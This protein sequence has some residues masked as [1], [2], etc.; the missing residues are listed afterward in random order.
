MPIFEFACDHCRKVYQFLFRTS[1]SRKRP[2][3]PDC[4]GSKLRKLFSRFS[5][6]R[7][8][9]ASPG[10]GLDPDAASPEGADADPVRMERAMAKLEREM[11]HLDESDPRQVGHFMRRMMEE[12]GQSLGPEME[13]AIRRLES[14]EDPEKIEEDMGDLFDEVPGRGGPA[15][16][17]DSYGY[18][19]T[20]YEP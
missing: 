19:D 14:G 1:T 10:S 3:C 13:T 2:I 9:G 15:G 4:G 7:G 16:N 18:D 5:V 6:S 20:L 17:E 8:A 11:T 12:T